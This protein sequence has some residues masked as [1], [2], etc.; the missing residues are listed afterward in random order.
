MLKMVC[1]EQ[2]L[3]QVVMETFGEMSDAPVEGKGAQSNSPRETKDT[4]VFTVLSL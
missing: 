2:L 4:K 3:Y 1:R